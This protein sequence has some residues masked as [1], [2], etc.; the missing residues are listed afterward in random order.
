MSLSDQAGGLNLGAVGISLPP[1][2][3]MTDDER[4][5]DP[6]PVIERMPGNSAVIFR[7]YG[8]ADRDALATRVV[9]KAR[10]RDVRV[11]IA[12]DA[13]LAA[14]VGAD[15]LHIPEAMA[16]RGPGVHQAW[17]R[18]S[19]LVTASA[20][21]PAALFRA[22]RAGADAVL[23]APVFPTASHPEVPPLGPVRFALWCRKSPLPV[24]ALGGVTADSWQRLQG[25]GAVGFAGIGGF[26]D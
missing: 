9:Q 17:R 15:G 10:R 1:F 6:M 5:A 16:V 14:R 21:S 25:S 26:L 2:I 13:D 18:R 4:L 22:A 8:A 24:Y 20:H 3:L 19:W 12:A 23:L 11:L 7:H